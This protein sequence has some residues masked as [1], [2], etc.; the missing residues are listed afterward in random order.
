MDAS[1]HG[2]RLIDQV[3]EIVGRDG[4]DT[5]DAPD[6]DT[7]VPLPPDVLDA[8]TLPDGRPLP[9]SLRRWLAFDASWL[10]AIGW[11][12]DPAAPRFDAGTLSATVA[13]MFEFGPADSVWRDSFAEF[14]TLLPGLCLPLVGGCDSRR[15]LYLG[16]PDSHGEYP[17]LV[18]DMDD[19]PY[20]GVEYPGLDVYLAVEAGLALD[21]TD[22]WD[23]PAEHPEYGP[24]M[25]Q[26]AI[27]TGLG[28]EGLE[29]HE[30][31]ADEEI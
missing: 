4:W 15:F 5:T 7:A 1:M 9:P 8:L 10:A 21:D 28:P 6:I 16:E 3:I 22:A 11:Y 30:L 14:E 25:Q 27:Q 19:I 29:I 18:A 13:R 23:D 17:V 2:A 12:A 26:H 31:Y 24:R 20:V